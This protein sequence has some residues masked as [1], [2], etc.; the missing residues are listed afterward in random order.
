MSFIQ[1]SALLFGLLAVPIL[2]LYMLRIRRQEARVPSTLLWAM[3]LRDRQANTPW[4]KLRRN[5]LLLLQLLI[6]ASIVLALARPTIPVAAVAGDSLYILLDASASMQAGDVK[7]SRFEAARREIERMISDMAP[8]STMSLILVGDEPQILASAAS[9]KTQLRGALAGAMPGTGTGDW[10][11]ALALAAGAIARGSGEATTVIVSDGGLGDQALPSLPSEV[12]YLP[13]GVSDENLAISAMALRSTAGGAELFLEVRN[14]GSAQH[15]AV[16]SLYADGQLRRSERIDLSPG[17]NFGF[18]LDDLPA[19]TKLYQARLEG[20]GAA[21]GESLDAFSLD[22]SAYAI[23]RPPR[24]RRALLFPYQASPLRYNIFV[25]KVLLALDDMA[26]YRAVPADDGGLL[27]PAEPFD[28][29]VIDG[30]WPETL[31]PGNLLLIDPPENPLFAVGERF[32]IAGPIRVLEHPLTR[33]F[34]WEAVHLAQARLTEP[35]PGSQIL[36]E[37][38]GVPLV[39]LA[40]AADR[41]LA[42]IA[43]DLHDSDLPLQV[44]FPIVFAQLANILSPPLA[45]DD[46]ELQPGS[47]LSIRPGPEVTHIEVTTPSGQAYG[48]DPSGSGFIFGETE[49]LGLYRVAFSPSEAHR[50]DVFAVNLFQEN[51]SFIRPAAGVR[52]GASEIHGSGES[53][54]GEREIWPWLI[55]LALAI[56]VVEW[57]VAHQRPILPSIRSLLSSRGGR[58]L[59]GRRRAD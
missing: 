52:I 12:R 5:L 44:T 1:P 6:L 4:Q 32:Q 27:I 8:G 54:T 41:R 58:L 22:D 26:P 17:Q 47:P 30:L 19:E 48:L 31:P 15:Q 49:E 57:W 46:L 10:P 14:Y 28:L 50:E 20:L 39:Y 42:V 9:D 40:E 38:E 51:E 43:F 25:E 37:A 36:V 35:P 56:L 45:L 16:L 21:D 11:S 2:L 55:F 24:E 18:V 33:Y 34:D 59:A 13:I 3:V 7:P 53:G 29:Y 23:Y